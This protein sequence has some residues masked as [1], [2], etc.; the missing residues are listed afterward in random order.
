[1]RLVTPPVS[2]LPPPP[3]ARFRRDAQSWLAWID[4]AFAHDRNR[5]LHLRGVWHRIASAR[6]L[7]LAHLE[8]HRLLTLELAA[9][10]HDVGRAIDPADSEPHAF[11]GARFLDSLGLHDVASLVAHHSGAKLEALDR[12]MTDLDV[13]PD[14]DR[15]LLLLLNYADRTISSQGESVGLLQRRADIVQRRGA[16]SPHVRRFDALL[17]DLLLTERTFHR[18]RRRRTA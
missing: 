13:W 9:L 16:D 7:E 5:A 12:D 3:G 18:G 1:M 8:T 6:R 4:A 15:E 10:V 11:A 17:P 2:L 14:V